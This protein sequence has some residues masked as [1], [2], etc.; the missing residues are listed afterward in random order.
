MLIDTFTPQPPTGLVMPLVWQMVFLISTSIVLVVTTAFAIR[1]LIRERDW[2]PLLSV[3]G[4]LLV[5]LTIEFIYGPA[6]LLWYPPIGQIPFI[7]AAGISVPLFVATGDCFW[8]G[9]AMVLFGG[10][11][12]KADSKKKIWLL[13]GAVLVIDILMEIPGTAVGVFNYYGNQG[14]RLGGFPLW[15][16]IQNGAMTVFVAWII[17]QL[18][19]SYLKGW[20][21]ILIIPIIPCLATASIS[22]LALFAWLG[23]HTT[24]PWLV[25]GGTL[26]SMAVALL[27]VDLLAHLQVKAFQKTTQAA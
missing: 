9:P 4:G 24:S 19:Q 13:F 6:G 2:V 27:A 21:A 5:P 26:A 3:F 20:R 18:R 17:K 25:Q 8:Y 14:I 23:I 11:V 16:L 12:S 1:M 10:L 7:Q 15:W 22:F